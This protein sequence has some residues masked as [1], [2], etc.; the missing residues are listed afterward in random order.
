MKE[1]CNNHLKICNSFKY[2]RLKVTNINEVYDEIGRR[3]ISVNAYLIHSTCF[4]KHQQSRN[5]YKTL[6]LSVVLYGPPLWS[7]GR[8]F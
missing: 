2:M 3:I 8:S 1:L 7:S 5:I 4:A 6:I